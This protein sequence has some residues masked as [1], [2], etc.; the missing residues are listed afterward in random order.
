MMLEHEYIHQQPGYRFGTRCCWISIYRGAPSDAPVVVCEEVPELNAD[1][2][3]IAGQVAAGVLLEHFRDG[4]PELPRPLIWVEH[5]PG[6]RKRE[7]GAYFLLSFS[8]YDP[9][10][11]AVGFVRPTTLG[12]PRREVLGA[13]E[14]GILLG[15]GAKHWV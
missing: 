9:R 6:R 13:E 3:D 10:P 8:S 14:V 2:S 11:A 1:V 15:S 12:R 7:R 4:L 5:H